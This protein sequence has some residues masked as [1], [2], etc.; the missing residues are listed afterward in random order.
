M[1]NTIQYISST[2]QKQIT[3]FKHRP[4]INDDSNQKPEQEQKAKF[5]N[6]RKP[7]INNGSKKNFQRIDIKET[8]KLKIENN[9][10]KY[11]ENTATPSIPLGNQTKTS[12]GRTRTYPHTKESH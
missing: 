11:H 6:N 4:G 10:P 8:M 3:H 1:S 2:A 5:K 12:N 7:E 9:K